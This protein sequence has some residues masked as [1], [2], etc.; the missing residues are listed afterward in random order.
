MK[1]Q[2]GFTV[3]ELLVAVVLLVAAGV[4]FV[5][6]KTQ[7]ERVDRDRQRKTAINAMY[8]SLEEVYRPA[9]GSYPS[10]LSADNLKSM[11]PALFK[12]P[13][14]IAIGAQ[15][16]DYRYDPT[17]CNGTVCSGYTLRANLEAEADFVK[18]SQF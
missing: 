2:A 12:D 4:L 10:T 7:I 6:Q 13:D 3:I 18:K 17:N 15:G 9:H 14:G 5:Q 11:D 8:Y 1:K 16:S